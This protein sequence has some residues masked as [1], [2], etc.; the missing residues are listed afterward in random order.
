MIS[1]D[2]TDIAF[3]LK[4][5]RDLKRAR[6][7]FYLIANRR[8]VAASKVLIRF[9]LALRIPIVWFIRPTFYRQFFGGETL[10]RCEGVVEELAKHNV[11]SILGYTSECNTR[12][13]QYAATFR[14]ILNTIKRSFDNPNIVFNICKPSG[15]IDPRILV[16]V[17][18]KVRLSPEDAVDYN[19]FRNH[20]DQLCFTSFEG[21]KALII[22]AEDSECQAAID[23]IATDMMQKYNLHKAIV[24]NTYQMYRIDRL[25]YLF[26]SHRR[27]YSEGYFLG[28]S[29]VRGAYLDRERQHAERKGNVS[30]VHDTKAATDRDFNE[31]LKYALMNIETI[32]VYCGTHN[33]D[34]VH[35]LT[36]L[37]DTYSIAPS[38]KRIFFCQL[39]GMSDN[40]SFN[41]AANEYNVAKYIPYGTVKDAIPYLFRR[42]EENAT[43]VGQTGRELGYIRA[44]LIRRQQAKK[45]KSKM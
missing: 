9:A 10:E 39:Y 19:A 8:L 31:A 28:A 21:G 38:D 27:A 29:I 45:T 34:S 5:T 30:P 6:F 43:L 18:S 40:I 35:Y 23:H 15:L 7:I 20:V 2:Y 24:Y 22:E 14:Q 42:A 17:S 11:K 3:A 37:M 13:E 16:A 1:F 26:D 33:E 36:C 25:Q 4:S 44:E 41:L 32:S 12:R